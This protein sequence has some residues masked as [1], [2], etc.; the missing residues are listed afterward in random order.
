MR[1][2]CYT[3]NEPPR[4]PVMDK[5]AILSIVVATVAVPMLAAGDR[6]PGRGMRRV[7]LT[8]C[9]ISALYLAYVVLIHAEYYP[10]QG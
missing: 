7:V 2:P 4:G 10:P 5:L 1:D 8:M 3:W 9:M 6:H